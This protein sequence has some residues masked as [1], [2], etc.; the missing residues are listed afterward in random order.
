M[1]GNY[2]PDPDADRREWLLLTGA[3]VLASIAVLPYTLTLTKTS[4][5][6]ANAQRQAAGKRAISPPLMVVLS[7]A[8]SSVLFGG[9]SALGLRLARPMGLG[10]P[11]IEA[12]LRGRSPELDRG[13][14]RA[15]ALVGAGSALFI[16]IMDRVLFG[17]L[18][19][20]FKKAG[21][22]EPEAWKG[23]LA[24][25]YGAIGEEVLMRLGLQTIVAAGVRR[26]WGEKALPPSDSTMWIAILVSNVAFGAGHLPAAA[27]IVP[28]TPTLV[29]RTILLNALIGTVFGRL[30]WKKGLEA[31]MVAHGSADFVLHVGGALL[32]RE[33]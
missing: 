2:G 20:A 27:T 30:Y 11:H 22:R 19:V 10:A 23:F 32:G 28:L 24:S 14:L 9:L 17:K 25:F 13:E 3:S 18:Q 15:Y 26:L 12:A 7:A 8:Q 6:K 29:V 16:G 4:I 1:A 31:S 33:K 21:M 5:E